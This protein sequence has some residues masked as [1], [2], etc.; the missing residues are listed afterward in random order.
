MYKASFILLCLFFSFLSQ[1]NFRAEIWFEINGELAEENQVLVEYTDVVKA[2]VVVIDE[3]GNVYSDQKKYIRS[4]ATKDIRELLFGG[5]RKFTNSRGQRRKVKKKLKKLRASVKWYKHF[6]ENAFYSISGNYAGFGDGYTSEQLKEMHKS[7]GLNRVRHTQKRFSKGSM[8]KTV[9]QAIPKSSNISGI[10]YAGVAVG[11]MRYSVELK[12]GKEI[13][14]SPGLEELNS[15]DFE[16][17][18]W[19]ARVSRKGGSGNS[20]LDFGMAHA[21]LP[22]Y[23]G[24]P[25]IKWQWYASD[26]AK[27]VSQVMRGTVDPSFKYQSTYE[28][29]RK[30]IRYR[31]TEMNEEGVFTR[32]GEPIK[33][34]VDIFPG[35]I[36]V[37]TPGVDRHTGFVGE[38]YNENGVLDKGDLILHTAWDAPLYEFIGDTILGKP[39][40]DLRVLK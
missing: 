11:T 18:G 28:L 13:V 8:I 12:I 24:S 25:S 26:C 23:F 9:D 21:N 40:Q 3:N 22:Y 33:Y 19:V 4:G 17:M 16:Q 7:L 37:R 5:K 36:I 20:I 35:D 10:E 31:L 29:V 14:R 15:N 32:D 2:I 6:A 38:D 1:A 30:P 39:H 34:G 27:F